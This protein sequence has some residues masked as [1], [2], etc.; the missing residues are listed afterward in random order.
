MDLNPIE[1]RLRNFVTL[2][3]I[4]LAFT[5]AHPLPAQ[6]PQ[7]STLE[8]PP[9]GRLIDIGGRKLHLLCSGQGS[10]TVILMAGG[11]AFSIDWAL[12]QPKIAANTSVC[13]YDRAGLAWSDPGPVHETVE[14]TVAD[15][16]ALLLAAGEK[17]PYVLVGASI[18]GIFIRAYQRTFPDEVGG[19]LF[20]N[21]S[22][23]IGMKAGE[24]MGLIWDLTED[25]IRSV[26]PQPRGS[27]GP[28]P[29]SEGDP[30]DR[31]PPE[32]QAVRLRL[33]VRLWERWDPTNKKNAE[34]TLSW[35]KEFLEEFAETDGGKRPL[36]TLPVI[37]LSSG[38]AA[39][40]S[41]RQSRDG[42]AARLDFLS[43]NTVHIT[44]GGSGH[45]IH[46]YQPD[47]VVQALAQMVSAVRNRTPL[48]DH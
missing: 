10:P 5:A 28:A 14:Q 30:F 9:P 25:D 36:G 16:H 11:G 2:V 29:I 47:A 18:G 13:S 6:S 46:L 7:T 15:L 24:K 8:P 48:T 32:L 34:S 42:A 1:R 44:A 21:S 27:K 23:R 38:P 31:L 26:F 43:E 45:E 19:L 4:A 22:N 37:V 3:T 41:E 33:D 40:E 12:V 20:T 17:P 39:K 35:R